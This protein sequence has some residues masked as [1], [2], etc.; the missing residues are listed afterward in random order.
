MSGSEER[1]T[2]FRGAGNFRFW[3]QRGLVALDEWG[4]ESYSARNC[5]SRF[6]SRVTSMIGS[7]CTSPAWLAGGDEMGG[8][9]R[10][11]DWSASPLGYPETWSQSVKTA[12]SICL[13]SRVPIALW[14][15]PELRLVYNDTYIPFL[16]DTKHPAML[17]APG[18][19]AWGE[20][21][22]ACMTRWRLEERPR[23]KTYSCFSPGGCRARRSMSVGATAQSWRRTASRSKAPS[24][25][26]PR[27]PR[28]SLASGG[29]RHYAIS[30]PVRQNSGVPRSLAGMRPRFCAPIRWIFRLR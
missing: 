16:G 30:A 14:L 28:R 21:W 26:A 20:I 1:A 27:R 3:T 8:R 29:S 23:S 10:A 2:W 12:V 6:D 11:K 9:M 5:T 24:M 19:E 4:G 13:N 15:G 7:D 25:P 17:G 22:A 18:R